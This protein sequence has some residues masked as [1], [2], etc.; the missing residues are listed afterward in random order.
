MAVNNDHKAKKF[1]HT[2]CF[3][4]YTI[5][6]NTV[7]LVGAALQKPEGNKVII[8]SQPSWET[9]QLA[10]LPL[11][12][13]AKLPAVC[14]PTCSDQRSCF[15]EYVLFFILGLQTGNFLQTEG[16]SGEKLYI[17]GREQFPPF[18]VAALGVD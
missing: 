5:A 8:P 7:T 2:I 18:S 4:N 16:A 3:I 12:P 10:M 11:F 13:L 1:L 17:Q 15:A 6:F 14:R 9:H